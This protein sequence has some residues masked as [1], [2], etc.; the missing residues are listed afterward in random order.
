MVW[1]TWLPW[2]RY[3]PHPLIDEVNKL[4]K[5]WHVVNFFDLRLMIFFY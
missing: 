2:S 4:R 1:I 3:K 5:T